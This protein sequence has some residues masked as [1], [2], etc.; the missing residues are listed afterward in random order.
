MCSSQIQQTCDPRT[1]SPGDFPTLL[2]NLEVVG[3]HPLKLRAHSR[4]VNSTNEITFEGMVLGYRKSGTYS[5]ISVFDA[6]EALVACRSLGCSVAQSY[7]HVNWNQTDTC[8]Y[9]CP[10]GKK[11]YRK[12]VFM[13]DSLKCAANVM[14]LAECMTSTLFLYASNSPTDTGTTNRYHG[15]NVICRECG[16]DQ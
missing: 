14:N 5:A 13:V 8:E 10:D 3:T 7:D 1:F 12:C 11:A 4:L 16:E 6:T 9:K 2:T 15:V